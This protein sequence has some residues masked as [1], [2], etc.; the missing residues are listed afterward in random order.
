MIAVAEVAGTISTLSL[1]P[2]RALRRV[3]LDVWSVNR[4][5]P[6]EIACSLIVAWVSSCCLRR[7]RPVRR[8]QSLQNNRAASRYLGR[9]L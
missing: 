9:S 1:A 8:V 7:L 5:S 2:A 4:G 3:Q 6:V